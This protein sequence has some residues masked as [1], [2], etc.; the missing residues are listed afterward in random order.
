LE[1]GSLLPLS[2]SPRCKPSIGRKAA[3][4]CRTPRNATRVALCDRK[5][6]ASLRTCLKSVAGVCRLS[7]I[8]VVVRASGLRPDPEMPPAG[9]LGSRPE[10]RTTTTS[11]L[12]KHAR[13]ADN[14]IAMLLVSLRYYRSISPVHARSQCGG[15]K[16]TPFLSSADLLSAGSRSLRLAGS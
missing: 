5:V 13:K 15:P 16:G 6:T 14:H 11:G 3:A 12:L 4:S 7:P 2:S 8:S 9:H 10:A 1:C